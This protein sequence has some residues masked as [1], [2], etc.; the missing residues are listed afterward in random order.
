MCLETINNGDL[1]DATIIMNNFNYLD[2]RI[3][4]TN[5]NVSSIIP[6]IR[7]FV[8]NI[9]SIYQ[10]IIDL[11]SV[12]TP[13]ELECNKIYRITPENDIEFSLPVIDDNTKFYQ[14]YI[15]MN[16]PTY[17]DIELGTDW[18]FN[19]V[20]PA[21]T[22]AGKYNILYEYDGSNWVCG[23]ITRNEVV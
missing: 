6:N 1:A 10:N 17:Y 15:I 12:T 20:L 13:I 4:D 5:T 16:L 8:N 19:S 2:N 18:G 3:T 21:I 11:D 7:D 23:I 14:I 22:Q 9:L